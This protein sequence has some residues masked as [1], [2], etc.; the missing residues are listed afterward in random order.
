MIYQI[1]TRTYCTF[2]GVALLRKPRPPTMID[3]RE[4]EL[5]SFRQRVILRPHL[6]NS[7]MV[8]FQVALFFL[9]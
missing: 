4:A 5:N 7:T 2:W 8:G 9:T 3:V 6:I 1:C